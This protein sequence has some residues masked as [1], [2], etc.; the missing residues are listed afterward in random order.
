MTVSKFA[1]F[2]NKKTSPVS[3]D[4][5]LLQLYRIEEVDDGKQQRGIIIVL[6][7]WLQ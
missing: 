7:P 3:E 2:K 4:I 1:A 5:I 6:I